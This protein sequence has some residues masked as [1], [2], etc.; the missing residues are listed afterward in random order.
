[1]EFEAT[2]Q[3]GGLDEANQQR[4]TLK[5]LELDAFSQ[6]GIHNPGSS[7]QY[8]FEKPGLRSEICVES[9]TAG[10]QQEEFCRTFVI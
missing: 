3:A 5:C 2:W 6:D 4:G 9:I 10:I 8:F 1:M 7:A